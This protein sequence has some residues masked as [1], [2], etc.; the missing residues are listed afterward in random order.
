RQ[1]KRSLGDDDDE[2]DRCINN[3][4]GMMVDH[5]DAEN[6]FED[7]ME[8]D[9]EDDD[10]GAEGDGSVNSSMKSIIDNRSGKSKRLDWEQGFFLFTKYIPPFPFYLTLRGVCQQW[11][12]DL[13]HNVCPNVESIDLVKRNEFTDSIGY[14]YPW[15]NPNAKRKYGDSIRYISLVFPNITSM[16]FPIFESRQLRVPT[17]FLKYFPQLERMELFNYRPFSP[18][19]LHVSGLRSNDFLLSMD[20]LNV[21]NIT[22]GYQYYRRRSDRTS[23]PYVL[24]YLNSNQQHLRIKHSIKYG[25]NGTETLKEIKYLVEEEKF[26]FEAIDFFTLDSYQYTQEMLEFFLNKYKKQLASNYK[27]LLPYEEYFER[28][29]ILCNHNLLDFIIENELFKVAFPNA[30]TVAY[31]ITDKILKN[32]ADEKMAKAIFEQAKFPLLFEGEWN[33]LVTVLISNPYTPGLVSYLCKLVPNLITLGNSEGI[34]TKDENGCFVHNMNVLASYLKKVREPSG[35]VTSLV[36]RLHRCGCELNYVF[37]ETGNN[38]CH[39]IPSSYLFKVIPKEYLNM[40]NNEGHTPLQSLCTLQ[41]ELSIDFIEEV[42][43]I[44]NTNG[45]PLNDTYNNDQ[46]LLHMFAEKKNQ[47][48][49]ETLI[50]YG[51]NANAVDTFGKTPL[52]YM[53]SI[54]HQL[55]R[56]STLHKLMQAMDKSMLNHKDKN[57][58]TALTYWLEDLKPN[59]PSSGMHYYSPVDLSGNLAI[60]LLMVGDG[61]NVLDA[62]QSMDSELMKQ[63]N[64]SHNLSLFLVQLLVATTRHTESYIFRLL[65]IISQDKDI[66]E[67]LSAPFQFQDNEF[68]DQNLLGVKANALSCLITYLMDGFEN[69]P[70]GALF[71]GTPP[72][73]D[74]SVLDKVFTLEDG[75]SAIDFLYF[76]LLS[77]IPG[78]QFMLF[79]EEIF[80]VPRL[81][82]TWYRQPHYSQ[83]CPKL[84]KY[85]YYDTDLGP[86]NIL[87][88]CCKHERKDLLQ[89]QLLPN[90]KDG[91]I[92]ND[93]F[94]QMITAKTKNGDDLLDIA[95]KAFNMELAGFISSECSLQFKRAHFEEGLQKHQYDFCYSFITSKSDAVKPTLDEIVHVL[96]GYIQ[97]CEIFD[98][99][100]FEQNC[101]DLFEDYFIAHETT[102]EEKC[103]LFNKMFTVCGE[104]PKTAPTARPVTTVQQRSN[105][106]LHV[107][108]T[109]ETNKMLF[110][111]PPTPIPE[112]KTSLLELCFLHG[113]VFLTAYFVSGETSVNRRPKKI[114]MKSDLE[115]EILSPWATHQNADT[116]D[117][118][119]HLLCTNTQFTKARVKKQHENKEYLATDLIQYLKKVKRNTIF[120]LTNKNGETALFGAHRTQFLIDVLT[121]LTNTSVTNKDGKKASEMTPIEIVDPKKK[122]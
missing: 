11:L 122:N 44:F 25:D 51:V 6:H 111:Q 115:T 88:L 107:H 21:R 97:K 46:N 7:K 68:E 108:R 82:Y 26:S 106:F 79:L 67:L 42:S 28:R 19:Y 37:A 22:L 119:L 59:I 16:C 95:C 34:V 9:E 50:S 85:S 39:L 54:G 89:Y 41:G 12:D 116:G 17:R 92:T 47:P 1:N 55:V 61:C 53:H 4:D 102:L 81:H 29:G 33:P 65:K 70:I 109:L 66:Y 77:G 105:W 14:K 76:A 112:N 84:A 104:K 118:L 100:Q 96:C 86:L 35:Y 38:F 8:D 64:L 31:V 110:I 75:V 36:E 2:S 56:P 99:K 78:N 60:I 72:V 52:F 40:K 117:S 101:I 83:I 15:Y 69:S 62:I 10:G 18:L 98:E 3:G 74:K 87:Q 5:D 27:A 71:F 30:D 113:F 94:Q 91:L 93:E 48:V 63:G 90:F 114:F 49:I 23:F 121:P 13:Y 43:K 20:L 80:N 32:I 45:I 58:K 57:G 120:N 73:L 24:S 103:N